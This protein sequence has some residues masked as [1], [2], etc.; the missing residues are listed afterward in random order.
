MKPSDLGTLLRFLMI[1][2]GFALGYAIV[3]SLLINQV[4]W[5]ALPTSIV[6]Y[7]LCIPVAFWMQ[8]RVAFRVER[9]AKGGFWVY[10][11]TQLGSLSLVALI[12]TRFVSGSFLID[13]ALF[14]VTAGLAA[15]I[16]FALNRRFAFN[17]R[18]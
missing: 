3:T 11:G 15:L 18:A 7:A 14:L 1:G 12:T 16:S 9:A 2:G 10:L 6:L 5:P 4:G 17:P 8:K 13:T